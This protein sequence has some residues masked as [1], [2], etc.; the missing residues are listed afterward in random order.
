MR[1]LG[2]DP[3]STLMGFGVITETSGVLSLVS[4]GVLKMTEKDPTRKL[5]ELSQKLSHLLDEQQ[6]ELVG[7]EKLYFS[8][9]K[10]TALEVSQARGVIASTL[11]TR[12][13]PILEYGP[14]QI[15]MAITGYG[16]ADKESV[17]KMVQY[18]LKLEKD[19]LDDNASDAL[20]IA[21]TAAF[22]HAQTKRY[23]K[24]S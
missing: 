1:I 18:I 23:E 20:A 6:P 17:A 12:G 7:L 22:G 11:L 13:L 15:K 5:L 14:G 4:V 8:K 16:N 19:K 3:G 21:I 2:I 9:N 24:S 10:K